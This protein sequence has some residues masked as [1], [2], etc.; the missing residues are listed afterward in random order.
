[1]GPLEPFLKDPSVS[2]ILIN[3][4]KQVYV[5]RLG[6][7]EQAAVKPPASSPDTAVAE[8]LTAVETAMKA[9]GV[10]LTALNRRDQSTQGGFVAFKLRPVTAFVGHAAQRVFL[11]QDFARRV[12]NAQ[13]FVG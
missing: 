2:D 8:R 6:K 11:F 1:M 10:T 13:L 5:E 9:L 3:T 4:H 12:I 7:L